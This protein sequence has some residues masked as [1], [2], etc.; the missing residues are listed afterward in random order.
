MF[1]FKPVTRSFLPFSIVGFLWQSLLKCWK[2]SFLTYTL[3][4]YH[5]SRNK[6][7]AWGENSA[8]G[9]PP[10]LKILAKVSNNQQTM[11]TFMQYKVPLKCLPWLSFQG[12]NILW[13]WV[14]SN[15]GSKVCLNIAIIATMKTGGLWIQ[16]SNNMLH[17]FLGTVLLPSIRTPR[18][19]KYR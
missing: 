15:L 6:S 11:K 13:R 4:S 19:L 14:Q 18:I 7:I 3:R 16:I 17:D 8:S 10:P 2:G 5:A 12:I 1:S 9:V